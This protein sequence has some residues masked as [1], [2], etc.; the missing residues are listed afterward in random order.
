SP[1]AAEQRGRSLG[2]A[3][4]EC[5]ARVELEVGAWQGRR[6]SLH[7]LV[8][9]RVVNRLQRSGSEHLFDERPHLLRATGRHQFEDPCS[10]APHVVVPARSPQ[11]ARGGKQGLPVVRT[12]PDS[13]L[14]LLCCLLQIRSEEHT[15]ELQSRE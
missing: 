14:C 6:S 12:P 3:R 8:S 5:P 10:L 2:A 15:S 9:E 11:N 13:F 1:V 4:T 7:R